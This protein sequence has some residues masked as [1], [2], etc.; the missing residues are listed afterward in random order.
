MI[1]ANAI[2]AWG[3][4]HPWPT[5]EQVE[6]DLLLSRAICAIAS[7]DY[8]G[9]EL[10][11]RGGTALHKLHLERPFRYSEDLDYVRSSAS[12]IGELCSVPT[13]THSSPRGLTVTT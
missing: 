4:D 10:V 3:T 8:L 7:D 6:Q 11:F 2:T 12:G 1:P 5:R 9:Q 13:W